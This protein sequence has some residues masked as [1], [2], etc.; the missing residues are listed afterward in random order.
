MRRPSSTSSH[1]Q[2]QVRPAR[3]LSAAVA[4]A[5]CL[6]GMPAISPALALADPGLPVEECP[7]SLPDGTSC[8][9]GQQESRVTCDPSS[10]ERCSPPGR[11]LDQLASSRGGSP[12]HSK[13]SLSKVMISATSPSSTRST[14]MANAS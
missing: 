6:A 9:S 8:Y 13:T 12:N 5:L 14:S 11:R 1:Q 10:A 7:A 3:R 2:R 4:A